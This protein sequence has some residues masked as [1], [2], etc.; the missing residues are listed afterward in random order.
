M[1]ESKDAPRINK[2]RP[3]NLTHNEGPWVLRTASRIASMR[4]GTVYTLLVVGG[5]GIVAADMA[6]EYA[7]GKMTQGRVGSDMEDDD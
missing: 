3:P 4:W 1:E 6:V 2:S 7:V 5:A